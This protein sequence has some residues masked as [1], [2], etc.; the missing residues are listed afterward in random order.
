MV[1]EDPE[2][3]VRGDDAGLEDLLADDAAEGVDGGPDVQYTTVQYSLVQ[4]S[5]LQYRCTIDGGPDVGLHQPRV[6]GPGLEQQL[7]APRPRSF[8]VN[9]RLENLFLMDEGIEDLQP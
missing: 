9:K 8:E 7:S 6:A 2:V 3:R 5:T 1:P 4:Y